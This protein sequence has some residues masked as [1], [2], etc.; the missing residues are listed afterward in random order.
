MCGKIIMKN[1]LVGMTRWAYSTFQGDT[2][3]IVSF[4]DPTLREEK[5]LVTFLVV[6]NKHY[7]IYHVTFRSLHM[8]PVPYECSNM[9]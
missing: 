9:Q 6:L 1:R 7:A 5:G 8:N 3:V 2:L 4:P